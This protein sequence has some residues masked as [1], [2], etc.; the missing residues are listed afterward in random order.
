MTTKEKLNPASLLQSKSNKNGMYCIY[1]YLHSV[2]YERMNQKKTKKIR[3]SLEVL[4]DSIQIMLFHYSIETLVLW[5]VL[6]R[7]LPSHV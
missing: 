4:A 6:G 1:Y 2:R 7:S 3:S 5:P